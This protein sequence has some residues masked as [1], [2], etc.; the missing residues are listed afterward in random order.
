MGRVLAVA[1]L[2]K[3][4]AANTGSEPC[5]IGIGWHPYFNIPSGDRK[6]A[7]LKIPANTPALVDNQDDIFP[8]G[9]TQPTANS[10]DDFRQPRAIGDQFL[11]DCFIDFIG[12]SDGSVAAEIHDP[13]SHLAVKVISVS[14]AVKACQCYAPPD[15]SFLVLE[16]QF[17][18]GTLSTR[19]F[20][21]LA[22]PVSSF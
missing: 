3:V 16:P 22:T 14:S 12:D 13:A 19:R 4:T 21:R 20:G 11:D 1:F 17:N 2:L 7:K 10:K 15:K 18:T 9:V 5:P 8:S 6:Q